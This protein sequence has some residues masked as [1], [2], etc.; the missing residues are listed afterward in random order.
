MIKVVGYNKSK[1]L[2][3]K[4]ANEL[5]NLLVNIDDDENW[6]LGIIDELYDDEKKYQ[7]LI[8]TII[9]TG[10]TNPDNIFVLAFN[11]ANS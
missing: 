1:L 7:M 11:M 9:N 2:N 10:E 6:A 8:D 5:Y 4:L 3:S